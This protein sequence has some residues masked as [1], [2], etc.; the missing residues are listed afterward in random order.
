MT[1]TSNGFLDA[2]V[3]TVREN[4]LAAALV[5]GGAFWLLVGNEKLKALASSATDASSAVGDIWESNARAASSSFRRAVAPP[6]AP[7]MDG[8][9]SF[10]MVDRLRDA[11]GAAA[12]AVSETADKIKSRFDDSTS[13]VQ[14]KL[15][16]LG[17]PLP[18]KEAF[19]SAQSSVTDL[20]ER[21]PL[22]LGIVGAAIGAA[23]AGAFRTF[24]LE[25]EW[26]GEI[27]DDVKADLNARAGSVSKSLRKSSDTLAAE[28]GDAAT[29]AT[30]RLKQAGM[31]AAAAARANVST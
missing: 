6:T 4:P 23:V 15:G 28:L 30:D 5:G 29:E 13:Y 17:E 20:L 9:G 11:S 7:E 24:D 18:G 27:S 26:L 14:E 21:Q 16:S 22:V 1:N 12:N 2:L 31:D 19:T 8:D 10:Q 3:S 25:N